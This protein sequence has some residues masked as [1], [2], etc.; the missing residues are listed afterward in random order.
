[1]A[2]RTRYHFFAPEERYM[3]STLVLAIL[4]GV[5][6]VAAPAARAD[7]DIT[8]V[9][10]ATEAAQG[11]DLQAVGE[12]FK[13]SRDLAEFEA[14]LNDPRTGVNNLDLDDNGQVDYI[15]VV[16]EADGDTH[17]AILQA[18]LGDNDFQDVATIELARSGDDAC[19]MQVHGAGLIYGPDFYVAP[20]VVHVH[21]WPILTVMFAPAY[22]P[23]RS[24][25]YYRHYPV[26][27]RAWHPVRFAAYHRRTVVYTRHANFR[28]V[29]TTRVTT[30]SRVHY[31]PVASTRVKRTKV[32]VRKGPRGTTVHKK[33]TVHHRRR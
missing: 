28:V 20:L 12:L 29:R 16:E 17:V 21:A 3:K 18:A 10:P 30:V 2:L 4:F 22:H 5:M 27:W 23:Y 9:A 1:M 26:G 13:D 15:R 25:W 7:D 33:T 24:V 14:R 32:V 11:L 8:V 19:E 31:H 6:L